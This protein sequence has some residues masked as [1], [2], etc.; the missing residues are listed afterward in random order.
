MAYLKAY[1]PTKGAM[2]A[3]YKKRKQG[4][5]VPSYRSQQA[6][7][8]ASDCARGS[9]RG[10]KNI[11]AIGTNQPPAVLAGPGPWNFTFDVAEDCT[12][13]RL[14]IQVTDPAGTLLD[15][16]SQVVTQL[17]QN[18][19]RLISGIQVNGSLFDKTTQPGSNPVLGRRAIVSDQINISGASSFP[20]AH[21]VSVSFS[22]M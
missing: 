2:P 22:T 4:G 17:N 18:N 7:S 16:S 13:A 9:S 15:A 1:N 6:G 12:L 5:T 20:A 3:G 14:N 8:S 21:S 19:N 11:I 10:G